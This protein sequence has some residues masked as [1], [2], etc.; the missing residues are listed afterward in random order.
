MRNENGNQPCILL[1]EEDD[2]TR[3][4]LRQNLTR[5]GYRVLLALDEEDALER[6]G[7]RYVHADAVLINLVDKS[8]DEVLQ[9]GRRIREHAKYDGRT[10]L[11]VMADKFGADLEGTNVKVG[12]NDWIAYLEEH[13][14]LRNLLTHLVGKLSI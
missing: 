7:A 1:I 11:I 10:P 12:D 5:Y 13:D 3:P 9:A 14:Q 8:T 6:V 2:D 4:L